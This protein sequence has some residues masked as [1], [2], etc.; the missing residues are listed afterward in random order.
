MSNNNLCKCIVL[1]MTM[2]RLEN[3]ETLEKVHT[4]LCSQ[5]QPL[6]VK[7]VSLVLFDPAVPT[8]WHL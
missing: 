3:E 4:C 8:Q 6:R 7:A 2:G 1:S 5:F